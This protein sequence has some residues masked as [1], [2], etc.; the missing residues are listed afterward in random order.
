MGQPALALVFSTETKER[1]PSLLYFTHKTTAGQVGALSG[2][3]RIAKPNGP[4]AE[5]RPKHARNTAP[6]TANPHGMLAL[7]SAWSRLFLILQRRR[8]S[9][10]RAETNPKPN[11]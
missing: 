1:Q 6:K 11:A 7:V 4:E 5:T 3:L 2:S 10:A 8:K 9:G